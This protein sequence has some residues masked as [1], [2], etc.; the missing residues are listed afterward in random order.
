M[1]AD[2]AM[3]LIE[4]LC[5]A[6]G[7]NIR[8]TDRNGKPSKQ[9]GKSQERRIAAVFE[10]LTGAKPTPEQLERM[11]GTAYFAGM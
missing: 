8:I 11:G 7:R 6:V 4:S 9:A 2:D 5:D 3:D 1:K 10:A